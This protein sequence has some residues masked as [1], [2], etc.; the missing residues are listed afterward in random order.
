MK[1]TYDFVCEW[2]DDYD[3]IIDCEFSPT[4]K[5]AKDYA[6]NSTYKGTV[7]TNIALVRTTGD[8]IEGMQERGYAYFDSSFK[9]PNRFDNGYSVPVRFL[10]KCN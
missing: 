8:E 5:G 9:L 6:K 10:N 2:I 7:K 4:L 3:D 1:T